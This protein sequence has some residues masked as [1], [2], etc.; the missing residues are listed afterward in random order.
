VTEDLSSIHR[1]PNS[2]P[3]K[4][5]GV[6]DWRDRSAGKALAPEPVGLRSVSDSHG[7]KRGWSPESCAY[8]CMH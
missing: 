2:A 5:E 8:V 3:L 1:A 4:G 6:G 7:R